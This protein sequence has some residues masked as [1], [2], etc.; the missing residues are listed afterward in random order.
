[1]QVAEW[2]IVLTYDLQ[3][4]LMSRKEHYRR[5]NESAAKKQCELELR[6]LYT[7]VN[8]ALQDCKY[9]KPGG[10]EEYREDKKKFRKAYL[11]DG[12][13]YLVSNA[14]TMRLYRPLHL[15]S[16]IIVINRINKQTL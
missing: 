6:T 13:G 7:P 15:Q 2:Q 1:M 10:Y 11:G 4:Q 8:S 12:K 16:A 5:M 14:I 9:L 3:K